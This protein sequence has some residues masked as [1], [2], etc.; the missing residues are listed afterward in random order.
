MMVSEKWLRDFITTKLS[1]QQIADR[2]TLAGLEVEA[3][4][5]AGDSSSRVLVGEVLAVAQ[6]PCASKLKVCEVNVGRKTPVSI[7]CGAANVKVGM[8]TPAALPGA[9]LPDNLKVSK[10]RIRNIVSSGMLCSEKE[11]GMGE[12]GDGILELDA[13][14]KAGATLA[15]HLALDDQIIEINVTPN[16]GDCLSVWG[17]A[18]ELAA[19]TGDKLMPPKLNKLKPAS[20]RKVSVKLAA[21]AECP[22][23]CAR[24]IEN[25]NVIARTPDWMRGRLQRSGVRSISI[26]VDV[27]NYVMLELGQPLHA[28]DLNKLNGGITVRKAKKGERLT[29]LDGNKVKLNAHHLVIADD[30]AAVALAG[31]MGGL[32][33]AIDD[34]TK[35]IL[36]EGAYFTT[37]A[38]AGQARGFGL[39]TDAAHRFERGVDFMQQ[40]RAIQ[41]ASQLIASIAGG[42]VGPFIEV[43]NKRYL[44]VLKPIGL[45]H[46][47]LQRVLGLEISRTDVSAIL[48]KLGMKTTTSKAGWSVTPTPNRFDLRAEHDLIEEVVRIYGYDKLPSR[49]PR[50]ESSAAT[51]A[52]SRLPLSRIRNLLID[53]EYHEA[54]TYS[55]VDGEM[56]NAIEPKC[57]AIVLSNPIA[58]NMAHMRTTLWVGLFGALQNN[59]Q[60]Q[61]RRIRLFETGH[62]FHL[63]K[64]QRVETMRIA[65]VVTGDL[66][67]PQWADTSRAV[68]FYD[69]KGDVESLIELAAR[70]TEFSIQ[71]AAHPAL[72]T[73]Q[74]ASVSA[75]GKKIGFLG[76]ISPTVLRRLDIEQP[77][78]AFEL[79][80]KPLLTA[81]VPAYVPISRFPAVRRDLNVL[82]DESVPA[83]DVLEQVR[84]TAGQALKNLTLFDQYRGEHIDFGKKSL[85]FSLTLQ[86]SSRTLRDDEAEQIEQRVL[87]ALQKQLGAVLR[88]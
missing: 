27:T 39:H 53:R 58:E 71:A 84:K 46:E 76:Q 65:A 20:K 11:L 87:N 22:R 47:R 44:P 56:Q 13:T 34:D 79:N 40:E 49:Q 74:S 18:Q 50:V 3:I 2:L 23:Y 9:T 30:K 41:L 86:E 29:L 68:D 66:R 45:R 80:L 57:K 62:V 63:L 51:R 83:E 28:F 36:L 38:V 32:N 5:T 16:R 14:A 55:F 54:I 6:H 52:E 43:S 61:T 25:V 85:T 33:S 59:Y 26:V 7:V 77:V 60:R 81:M 72:H 24:V 12:D 69:L 88:S 10:A 73:G 37:D 4:A 31:V 1:A 21:P 15:E 64:G 8:K 82:V 19:L 48:K 35:D 78:F 42:Q 67:A 17:V 75:N 70:T